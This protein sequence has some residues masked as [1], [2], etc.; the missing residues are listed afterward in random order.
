MHNIGK[1]SVN[2]SILYKNQEICN[3]TNVP[4]FSSFRYFFYEKTVKMHLALLYSFIMAGVFVSRD[5]NSL[6]ESYFT[7][8]SKT[9]TRQAEIFQ[10]K[11]SY[12]RYL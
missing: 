9:I 3:K 7:N 8:Y 2:A 10:G 5:E 6:L 1:V 12:H 4:N 11:L